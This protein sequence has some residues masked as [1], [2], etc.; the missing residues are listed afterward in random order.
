[1]NREEKIQ[2]LSNLQN[3]QLRTLLSTGL[4]R[5]LRWAVFTVSSLLTLVGLYNEVNS[6]FSEV[7]L[8]YS[9][10]LAI[11]TYF[12][13]QNIWSTLGYS[14]IFLITTFLVLYCESRLIQHYQQVS[15]VEKAWMIQ[16]NIELKHY[17]VFSVGHK[18][19]AII[20]WKHST[21]VVNGITLVA[22]GFLFVLPILI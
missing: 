21:F 5:Q 15:N 19:D 3:D 10:N 1:M 22:I 20:Q 12:S 18:L 9:T 13:P 7:N 17:D 8:L 2:S 11:T 4:S 6:F 16:G 14:T